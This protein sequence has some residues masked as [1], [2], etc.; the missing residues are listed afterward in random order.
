MFLDFKRTVSMR[1]FLIA[2]RMEKKIIILRTK[3]LL[4]DD[5]PNI[6]A[7]NKFAMYRPQPNDHKNTYTLQSLNIIVSHR[8]SSVHM[9]WNI[10]NDKTSS[11]LK[12]VTLHI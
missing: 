10:S 4:G 7:L 9:V 5:S 8:V 2:I 11:F 3:S 1:R 12:V 6:H